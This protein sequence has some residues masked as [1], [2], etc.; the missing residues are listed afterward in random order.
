MVKTDISA[1]FFEKFFIFYVKNK[2]DG[3]LRKIRKYYS[4]VVHFFGKNRHI[5]C[6]SFR[7]WHKRVCH[8]TE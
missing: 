8:I 4:R 6:L 7:N 5:V 2:K 3:F 1:R